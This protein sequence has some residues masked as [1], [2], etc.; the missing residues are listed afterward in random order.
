[1]A[2]GQAL[3]TVPAAAAHAATAG[4]PHPRHTAPVRVAALRTRPAPKDPT[5]AQ[6]MRSAPAVRWPSAGYAELAPGSVAG[7]TAS[8]GG[9]P[10]HVAGSVEPDSGRGAPGAPAG[11][12]AATRAVPARIGVRVLPRGNG[13]QR[14]VVLRLTRA[15]GV[16]AL[17]RAELTVDA[18]RFRDAYGGGWL[19]RL[20][21]AVLPGCALRTPSAPGC[22]ARP[23]ATRV[24][25]ATGRLAATVDVAPGTASGGGTLVT[26]ASTAASDGGDYAATPLPTTGTWSAGGSSGD[27]TWTYPLR[28]PPGT[29]GMAPQVRLAYSSQSVDGLTAASNNQPSWVGEGFSPGMASITRSYKA[30]KDD[31]QTGTEDL[32]WGG[33]NATLTMDGRGGELIPDPTVANRWHIS[34]DDGSRIEKLTGAPNGDESARGVAEGEYWKL[35]TQDGTQYFFGLNQIPGGADRTNST[36]LVP[37]FGNNGASG[38]EPAEP[39]H[40]STFATSYCDQAYQWS[41]DY[42]VDPHGNTMSYWYTRETNNYARVKTDTAVSG[43]TR[44]LTL[45]RIEYGTRQDNGVDSHYAA[46]GVP[47]RVTFGVSDRC[48]TA[49]ATCTP[50]NTANWPDVPWDQNCTST[51]SCPGQY[52]ATFWTQKK[53]ST[54]TT[55]IWS[56]SAFSDV[57]RWTLT[58]QFKDPGDNHAKILWLASIGHTG[59]VGTSVSTPDTTLDAVQLNNRVDASTSVD[60][61]IRYRVNS[62]TNETG[63]TTTV[64]YSN[65]ECVAGTAMPASPDT[66]TMR[67]FPVYWTPYGTTTPTF[68]W[69]HK[70]VVTQVTTTDATGG[71]DGEVV[72]YQYLD[73]PAWHY[74]D[75]EFVP[76]AHKS[77]GQWRGYSRVRVLSGAAN[78]TRSQTDTLFFRGMNG[79]RTAT[80]TRAVSVVD[81]AGGSMPDEPWRQGQVRETISYN[82]TGDAAS[83]VAKVKD[84][85]WEYGPTA[86]RT[87]NG[88]TVTAYLTGTKTTTTT[89]ALDAGRAP[90]VT[91][92]TNTYDTGTGRITMVDDEGD[93][94]TTAD[95]LC[96]RLTFAG[97]AAAGMYGFVARSETVKVS[98]AATPNRATDVVSDVRTWYDGAASFG[99]TVTRGDVTRTEELADWN[100]G[101]PLYVT[102]G[103]ASYDA[104][105]RVTDAW[106]AL[107]NKTSTA[108]L[109][110]TGGPVTGTTVTNPMGWT[111]STTLDPSWGTPTRTVDAN[112]RETTLSYDG[113][114]RVTGIWLPGR[115][116]ADNSASPSLKFDY[117]IRRTGGP[118][119]VS[120]ATLNAAGTGYLTTYRLYDGFA[121]LRQEQTPS[122]GGG[123]ILNDTIRESR[124]LVSVRTRPYA[125][126]SPPG[127]TLQ[128]P[129]D[130]NGRL[131]L[132]KV[133][134]YTSISYDSAER[135][136]L[137]S[138]RVNGVERWRSS[139]YYAG[140]RV[141]VTPPAGGTAT[142][143]VLD[144]RGRTAERWDYQGGAPAGNHDTTRYTYAPDGNL[145]TMVDAT[146]KN[147]WSWT[148]D[149]RGRPTTT[150]DPDKGSTTF[151][152]DDAGHVRTTTDA[153]GTTLAY[154][155]DALGRRTATHQGSDTGTTLATWSYDTLLKGY[156]D[157]STRY[158]GTDAYTVAVTGYD[159]ANRPLGT[160][161]TIPAAE[162]GLAGQY[163]ATSTYNADGSVATD[164]LPAK[165]GSPGFGGLADETVT[166]GYNTVGLPESLTGAVPYVTQRPDKTPGFVYDELDRPATII[167]GG[168]GKTVTEMFGYEDGTGRLAE[169]AVY[170]TDDVAQDSY[171]GYDDAGNL[172][173]ISNKTSLYGAGPDD[174][175]CFRHDYAGRL[176]EAWTPGTDNCATDPATGSLGGPA[177]YWQSYRYDV[178]GNR[179]SATEHTSAAMTTHTYTYPA[180]GQPR[181]HAVTAVTTATATASYGYDATGNTNG[182]PGPTGQQ[183]LRWDAEGNLASVTDAGHTTTYTYD[184]DGNRLMAKDQSGSTLYLDGAEYRR[185]SADG[186]VACTRYYTLGG[187]TIA[188]RTP[189]GLSW[190]TADHHGTPEVS[191]AAGA[192]TLSRTIRYTLPF[193]A[194]RG[195]APAWN[196]PHGFVNGVTDQTGLTHLGARDYDPGIGRFVSVDPELDP[197]DPQQINGYGYANNAPDTLSDPT[198]RNPED[199]QWNHP[200]SYQSQVN[201]EARYGY[202][203]VTVS[204]GRA[205]ASADGRNTG[206]YRPKPTVRWE[207][208]GPSKPVFCSV[209]DPCHR[210]A[211]VTVPVKPPPP[212]SAEA[213]S[214]K[215][216]N[217]AHHEKAEKRRE[218]A[219]K[220]GHYAGMIADALGFIPGILCE[221]CE[222]L[223]VLMNVISVTGYILAQQAGKAL[224]R[225]VGAL[226]S[227]LLGRGGDAV[228]KK[229]LGT[230]G[231]RIAYEGRHMKNVARR[232][233]PAVR[234]K[235]EWVA[236]AI[237]G[238]T[239]EAYT[240][241]SESALEGNEKK[242][243]A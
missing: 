113:L 55:Q 108:Y 133:P 208:D 218:I 104:N 182:R 179:T 240:Y 127:T 83:W 120:T 24:D 164:T 15:D 10:V 42:V 171:Y 121:Q 189:A 8:I 117:L 217:E 84:D 230:W 22:A 176:A 223:A 185:S 167:R 203:P 202:H 11:S 233:P 134:G 7:A 173:S 87:R 118:S 137:D 54:V 196:N 95:D 198:G 238:F 169:H 49:G 146:G 149:Q 53:L 116:R 209:L 88:V 143:T 178:A 139:R 155:Y 142:A 80:G 20:R 44:A 45:S 28:I 16:A 109:P 204:P 186:A 107:G 148:Y 157:S 145:A 30:C 119:A 75:A 195:A 130:V 46:G 152:Y 158:V 141:D 39:C 33:D 64:T 160:R 1:V 175:Q 23:L 231:K 37:V 126:T 184:A 111:T 91:R 172:T 90:R 216:D 79:D 96:T 135:A 3:T 147:N 221:A 234:D 214:P 85:P 106:D 232:L 190:Q 4:R 71:N 6:T 70:Y 2:S 25:P 241:L 150:S 224:A 236:S 63:G 165:V 5:A 220:M 226:G 205:A 156:Q 123:A 26:L 94:G 229:V 52:A 197:A 212:P 36:A 191:Y 215:V 72:S 161:V 93:T 239:D 187:S 154:S 110:A 235:L 50:S 129:V 122:P 102:T 124:G 219:E 103:R 82:G 89:T 153:A 35:T 201:I 73:K 51:T 27:F 174:N 242:R 181:P 59:T 99:T 243:P 98:C 21:L 65:P 112:N 9:L 74:D 32:C 140:D 78:Q 200:L 206:R 92:L 128:G 48:V 227:L 144:A 105:G 180:P 81:S 100:N 41:L 13:N 213:N 47:A 237:H 199:A 62:I 17:G 57:E 66:N 194:T 183:T 77:W 19:G 170:S 40:Q 225:A 211:P 210:P 68:G 114:G 58:Q 168:D 192:T 34:G 163:T 228:I 43:Y 12:P 193:G 207:H 177:P 29:G 162:T 151:T 86:S 60:P 18:S 166:F 136:T 38:T 69:F 131:D 188:V 101:T 222:A 14:M 56:G 76:A 97:N 132:T 61:I 159:T 31:G 67:C 138:F 125:G 115:A